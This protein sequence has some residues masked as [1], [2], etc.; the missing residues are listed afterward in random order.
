[1]YRL[2]WL[3]PMRLFRGFQ[4]GIRRKNMY[5]YV[6]EGCMLAQGYWH[7]V[8]FPSV[9]LACT[10]SICLYVTT[11]AINECAEGT[12]NCEQLCSDTGTGFTCSCRSGYTL[13]SD[14]A[15]CSGET[16]CMGVSMFR[17]TKFKGTAHVIK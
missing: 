9:K 14:Q 7:F 11:A 12:N 16:M 5:R 10:V 3:I 4:T 13:N 2:R 17:S 6:T 8:F 15:T 1:M